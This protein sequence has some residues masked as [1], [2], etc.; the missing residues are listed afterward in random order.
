MMDFEKKSSFFSTKRVIKWNVRG[1]KN[2]FS[3]GEDC[4]CVE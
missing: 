1:E 3:F 4:K 2:H